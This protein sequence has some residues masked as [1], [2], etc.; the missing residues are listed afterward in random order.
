[1]LLDGGRGLLRARPR[2]GEAPRD[3]DHLQSD[4]RPRRG[5]LVPVARTGRRR[6][7]ARARPVQRVGR[8]DA[9][10]G[11]PVVQPIRLPP[12]RRVAGRERN[13]RRRGEALRARRR[14]RED[15][16]WDLRRGGSLSSPA[17]AG[18]L[19][20]PR[21]RRVT[22]ARDLSTRE[23]PPGVECQRG[24]PAAPGDARYPAVCRGRRPGTRQAP[25]A[26]V[27]TVADPPPAAG[28]RCTRRPALRAPGGRDHRA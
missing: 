12:G 20:R 16:D 5:A 24:D 17:I 21:A 13:V 23:E 11:A 25:V 3:V 18:G 10:P 1:V 9:V 14:R 26:R 22:G 27:A 19:C 2:R 4:P 28:R 15:R 8:S 6:S 7:P